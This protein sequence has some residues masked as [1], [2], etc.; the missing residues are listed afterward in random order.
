MKQQEQKERQAIAETIKGELK[1]N[2]A[3]A[4]ELA[5]A[6][7]QRLSKLRDTS[8][9]SS[10]KE[11]L[12]FIDDGCVE[13]TFYGNDGFD[14]QEKID[15]KKHLKNYIVNAWEDGGQMEL[16]KIAR[17]EHVK[18]MIEFPDENWQDFDEMYNEAG[19]IFL[20]RVVAQLFPSLQT[21]EKDVNKDLLEALKNAVKFILC[22]PELS[23]EGQRPKGLERWME[24]IENVKKETKQIHECKVCGE[25]FD[26]SED[27]YFHIDETHNHPIK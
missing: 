23:H 22:C 8:L 27:L 20:R 1:M 9:P 7:L 15:G 5:D 26:N 16:E 14:N 11:L 21:K 12:S 25:P 17:A 2:F 24:L 18:I 19:G 10:L 6:I 13:I 4:Y 3:L